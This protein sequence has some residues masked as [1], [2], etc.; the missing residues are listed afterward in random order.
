MRTDIASVEMIK[1]AAN[2]FLATKISIINEIV[3]VSEVT[4]AMVKIN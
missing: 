1:L 2:A 4:G 3:N